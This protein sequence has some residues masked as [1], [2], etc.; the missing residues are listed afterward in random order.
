LILKDVEPYTNKP[1]A[2]YDLLV[3]EF[4]Q[5]SN[6][7]PKYEALGFE[8]CSSDYELDNSLYLILRDENNI[9][10]IIT[11][12]VDKYDKRIRAAELCRL[13]RLPKTNVVA[14]H[15]ALLQEGAY[16]DDKFPF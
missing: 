15:N 8:S 13:Y 4:D 3:L 1:N 12:N 11:N 16:N 6:L 5:L 10:L 2:H 9:N 14:I 7:V